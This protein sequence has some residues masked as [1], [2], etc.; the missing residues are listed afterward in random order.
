MNKLNNDHAYMAQALR[1]A[2]QG[3]YTTRTNPR[4]GCVIVKDG[5]VIGQGFHAYPGKEHAEVNA[6][7]HVQESAANSTM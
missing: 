3:L 1:L 7:N 2:R 4:V 5:K 6:L